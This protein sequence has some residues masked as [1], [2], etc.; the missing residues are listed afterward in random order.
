[1]QNISSQVPQESYDP[2]WFVWAIVFLLVT[3]VS[4]VSYIMLSDN[5]AGEVESVIKV[6][7]TTPTPEIKKFETKET[8]K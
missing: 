4:L 2:R 6:R 7:R 8:R 3:G 1:M 5:S